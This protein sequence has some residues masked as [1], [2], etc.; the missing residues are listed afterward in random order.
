MKSAFLL[1]VSLTTIFLSSIGFSQTIELPQDKVKWTFKVEQKGCEATIIADVS[2]VSGWE[3]NSIVLPKGSFGYATGF[4]VLKS[5][6]IELIGGPIEPKPIQKHE[7]A[8][9]E[10]LS[11]H[12]G[13]IQFKQKIKIL[14]PKDFK[15]KINY[16]YQT[17]KVDSYCL[18]PFDGSTTVD[19]KGCEN[20]S[21]E[22][23]ENETDNNTSEQVNTNQKDVKNQVTIENEKKPEVKSKDDLKNE[24]LWTIFILSFASGLAA[25]MT[26]CVF[27]MLPMTVS[28]FTKRS[29]SRSE[30]IKNAS[31]YS[32]SIIIIFVLLGTAV[33]A[34]FGEQ[35]LNNLATNPT[36]NVIFFLLLIVFAV[37]FMGAFEIR[38][39]SSWLNKVDSASDKGGIIGIFFMALALALVS[40]SCTGPIVSDLILM[41]AKEGGI[42][43]IVGM[44]GFSFAL[45]LPFGL[46]AAFPGWMNALPKSGGW[47]NAV[48]VVLGLLELAL[49]F[50]FLSNAD[51]SLQTHLL[52]REVFLAI[53]IAIFGVL[54][55][56]LLGFITFP[57]DSKMERVPVGRAMLG[58]TVLAFVIYMIPG[59]WGAPLNLISAFPPPPNYS[60]SPMG[61]GGGGNKTISSEN[62]TEDMHLGPQNIM[63]F[64]D[65][66][67]ALAYSKKVGKPLFVDFTGHNCVNC[68]SMEQSVWNQPGIIDY[69]KND[70]VI[71][72]LHIDERIDLPKEEQIEVEIRPGEKMKLKT[73]GD[74]WFT[75][76]IIEFQSASQPLYVMLGPDGKPMS[77]GKADY[78]HHKNP[79][80]FKKWIEKGLKEFKK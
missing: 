15:L 30:G 78:E 18:A 28:F 76:E 73:T 19:V 6:D 46:F 36:F 24:S 17:C 68:R 56:Y 35:A 4:K 8:S 20:A 67:K 72:S 7:E 70:V 63:V 61:F 33:V 54:A 77:N 75:K 41:S 27:P 38:L 47:L 49:A 62:A 14:N 10:D 37:S 74:K 80:D 11:Y 2:I 32:L 16:T 5:K 79:S 39:P 58:M 26:P 44:F 60:E 29:K 53:W 69:L 22:I 45:S 55:L 42:A 21:S 31:I 51:L 1:F 3:I 64:H 34:I 9:D 57:H 43:P 59:M 50:K 40:F 25:L 71:A 65:Y 52:E 66:D 13:K 12:I 48:K 23:I